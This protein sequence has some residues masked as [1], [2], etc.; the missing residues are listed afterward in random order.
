MRELV[1][2]IITV[3]TSEA[4][5]ESFGSKMEVYHHRFTNSDID[6]N[7]VQ[8]EMFV[9][10]V[11]P[12]VGKC[13]PFIKTSLTEFGKTFTLRNKA[14]KFIGKGKVVQHK[15]KEPYNYPFKF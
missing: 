11:G 6:D 3:S 12:P 13:L 1:L 2:R 15:L 14:S 4:I 8:I 10:E 9:N 5:C 7:Q